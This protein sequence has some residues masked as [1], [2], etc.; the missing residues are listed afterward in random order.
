MSAKT[1]TGDIT[2]FQNPFALN[3][4][5]YHVNLPNV[6]ANTPIGIYIHAAG[7]DCGNTAATATGITELT[8][9]ATPIFQINGAYVDGTTSLVNLDGAGSKTDISGRRISIRDESGTTPA[10]IIGCS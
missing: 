10:S 9:L 5:K 7:G 6:A 4:A 2:L 3:N 8:K 1:L